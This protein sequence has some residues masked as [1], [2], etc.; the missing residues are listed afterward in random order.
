[1]ARGRI[2]SYSPHTPDVIPVSRE[3]LN[4]DPEAVRASRIS[5]VFREERRPVKIH[6]RNTVGDV[7]SL[8]E[9]ILKT[10]LF[11]NVFNRSTVRMSD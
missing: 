2:S 1:M 10:S 7:T 9:Q 5:A 4:Q 3:S 8:R 11:P 6:N